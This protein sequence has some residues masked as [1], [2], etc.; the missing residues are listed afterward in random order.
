MGLTEPKRG[1]ESTAD[2]T[3]PKQARLTE[4]YKQSR[5]GFMMSKAANAPV[6]MSSHAVITQPSPS[7][8]GDTIGSK[9]KRAIA[10]SDSEDSDEHRGNK[11][12]AQ[13]STG[14]PLHVSG[15]PLQ[16]RV[17]V[18]MA[19]ASTDGAA[20]KGLTSVQGVAN[21]GK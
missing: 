3:D 6:A 16:A 8:V 15:N 20:V 4:F 18:P 11:G 7:C 9:E 13:C 17:D 14:K 5:S 12:L 2:E 10:V 1:R 21:S 19:D